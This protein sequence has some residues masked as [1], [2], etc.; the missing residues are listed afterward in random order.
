MGNSEALISVVA[1]TQY[2]LIVFMWETRL[3]ESERSDC[4]DVLFNSFWSDVQGAMKS[5]VKK[6]LSVGIAIDPEVQGN[7]FGLCFI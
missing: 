3:I 2:Q 4:I 6:H 5:Q 1:L 7:G